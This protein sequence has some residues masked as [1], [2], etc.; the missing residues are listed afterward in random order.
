MKGD[1]SA[2]RVDLL[3]RYVRRDVKSSQALDS[4]MDL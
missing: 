3:L 4:V 1:I 2:A